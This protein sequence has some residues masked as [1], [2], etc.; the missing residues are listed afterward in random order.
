MKTCAECRAETARP[1]KG[2]CSSCYQRHRYRVISMTR[3]SP[4]SNA[5]G[6]P[7]TLWRYGKRPCGEPVERFGLCAKHAAD[8]VRLGGAS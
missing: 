4:G 3:R 2:L 8:K 7:V 6:C 1:R 5:V